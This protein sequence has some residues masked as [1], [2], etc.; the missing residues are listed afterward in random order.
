[1]CQALDVALTP[2]ERRELAGG[3]LADRP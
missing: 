3:V 1:M 2:A